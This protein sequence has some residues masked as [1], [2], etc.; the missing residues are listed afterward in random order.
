MPCCQSS[1]LPKILPKIWLMTDPRFGDKLL[2]SVQKLPLGSGVIL[3]HYGDPQRDEIAAHIAKIC[4]R[5]GLM[6]VIAGNS[7]LR[8]NGHY[9]GRPINAV[10][11]PRRMS[12]ELLMIGVHDIYEMNR[13]RPL[14]PDLLL[15]SPIFATNSHKG[16]RPM[17]ALRFRQLAA[18]ST[19]VILALGGMNRPRA[20]MLGHGYA[21][22]DAFIG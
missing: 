15:L 8:C 5:R 21:A 16:A 6:L 13:A 19:I 12:A 22:I 20:K 2:R 14:Q 18:C 1:K 11:R 10:L 9:Y 7:A 3:R 17:G 4:R